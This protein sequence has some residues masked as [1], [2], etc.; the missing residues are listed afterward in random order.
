MDMTTAFQP[1]TASAILGVDRAM[2]D[3][4]GFRRVLARL[5]RLDPVSVVLRS[6]DP[7][8]VELQFVRDAIARGRSVLVV[9]ERHHAPAGVQWVGPMEPVWSGSLPYTNW[10]GCSLEV[11]RLRLLDNA[12]IVAGE[13][14]TDDGHWRF[15]HRLHRTVGQTYAAQGLTASEAGVASAP[16]TLEMRLRP[17]D[18]EMQVEGYWNEGDGSVPFAGRLQETDTDVDEAL[19]QGGTR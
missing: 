4:D 17:V 5:W 9:P 19:L 10:E 8:E 6:P 11:I 13:S 18:G 7:G 3:V 2:Y 16:F 14:V 15:E 12:L 1:G